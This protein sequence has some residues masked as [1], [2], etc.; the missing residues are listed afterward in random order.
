MARKLGYG[1]FANTN[2]A[3]SFAGKSG[4][5]AQ[6]ITV[7][8]GIAS[9]A[10]FGTSVITPGPVTITPTR[11]ESP[12]VIGSPLLRGGLPIGDNSY[13]RTNT[14]YHFNDRLPASG[15]HVGM[16]AVLHR[17]GLNPVICMWDHIDEK[18]KVAHHFE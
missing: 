6:A 13:Q 8:T 1:G 4:A 11:L 15:F 2:G 9:S 14:I 3:R 7:D 5:G 18:W 17:D 10:A 12:S 16:I